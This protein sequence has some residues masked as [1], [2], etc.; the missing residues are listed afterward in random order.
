MTRLMLMMLML[1][2]AAVVWAGEPPRYVCEPDHGQAPSAEG[3]RWQPKHLGWEDH[4]RHSP[5]D[6]ERAKQRWDELGRQL[7]RERQ[8]A[9]QGGRR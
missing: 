1:G 3:F 8:R 4:P 2:V 6:L 7:E 5:E 9:R